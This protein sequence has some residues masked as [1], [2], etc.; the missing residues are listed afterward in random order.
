MPT[1]LRHSLLERR[2]SSESSHTK[3]RSKL[4]LVTIKLVLFGVICFTAAVAASFLLFWD[5]PLR[6]PV[7]EL[8]TFRFLSEANLFKK[9]KKVV[10]GYLPYWNVS[11]VT[12]QPELT[13]LSYFGL[14]AAADGSIITRADGGTEPGYYRLNSDEFLEVANQVQANGGSIDIVIAQFNA[15]TMT[16][17]FTSEAAQ[18]TLI[19]SIDDIILAYPVSGVSLDFE[20]NGDPSLATRNGLTQFVQKLGTHLDERYDN[21]ELSIAVYASAS[22]GKGLWDLP[23]MEPYLDYIIVM[24]YDFHRRSSPQAGPVAPLFGGD[25]LWDSDINQHLQEFVSYIPSEKLLLGVP[26][27]GYE[28]QTTDRASQSNTF[29]ETGA[30]ASIER[31]GELLKRREE[32]E[33]EEHWNEDALS[34]YLTYVEDGE[35]YVLYYENSRSISYKLDYVNQL[36]LGGVAIWALGYEGPSRELWDVVEVKVR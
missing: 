10:Y 19:E 5:A 13:H 18:N 29:P 4:P 22:N 2:S 23:A 28:W 16:S 34:P 36:D 3:Q 14:T 24:A 20:Y 25:K 21:V 33:V 11:K 26:F 8:T 32:L 7:T 35:T 17:L 15:D 12:V 1:S 9:E 31:V 6:S 30:T 27:Y